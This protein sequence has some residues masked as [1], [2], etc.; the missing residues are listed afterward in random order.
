MAKSQA[1][2]LKESQLKGTWFNVTSYNE[3]AIHL[4]QELDNAEGARS[5]VDA[6]IRYAWK[7]YQQEPTR[8]APPWP[9]AADLTSPYAR[10]Y[11]DA[12]QARLMQTIF[13]DPVW[14]VEGWGD[15]AAKAPFVEEFHQR[16]LEEERL[17]SYL[18]EVTQRALVERV[19]ILEISEAMEWQ[20]V[21]KTINAQWETDEAGAPLMDDKNQPQIV[22]DDKG[23]PVEAQ[24]GMP[25]ATVQAD[26]WEPV[27]VGPAYDVVPYLDFLQLPGHARNKSHV[28]GFAKRFHRRVPQLQAWVER[29]LYDKAAVEAVG[30]ENEKATTANDVPN[31]RSVADQRGPTAQKELWEVQL[32]ANL[33]GKGERWYRATLHREKRQLLRLKLDDRTTRFLRFVPFPKAGSLDGY[34]L[35]TDVMRTVIEEDTAVRNMRADK[36]ALAIAAPIQKRQG[37]LWDEYEQPLGP[38]SVITVRDDKEVTQM[39]LSDVPTSINIWKQDIR[40]DSDRLVGQ[41][42]T[43]LGVDSGEDNTLGEERLR[44]SY[45][46]I[47]VDL[48]VKRMK[49]PMEELWQ[50]RHAIWQ[51]TLQSQQAGTLPIIQK[52]LT[53]M[54][55]NGIEVG[56]ITDGQITADAL[57]GAFWGKPRGSVETADLSRQRMDFVALLN[58]LPGLMQFNPMLAAILQ[59]P[60]ASKSVIE[61]LLR[62]FRWPDKQAFLGSAAQQVMQQMQQQQALMQDPQM[63]M[64]LALAGGGGA[65]PAAH[66]AGGVPPGAPSG[67]PSPQMP[68]VM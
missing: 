10:E 58:V 33:D 24:E 20:R 1:Y 64:I 59:T 63:Q 2:D 35:V 28:W 68:G 8:F 5:G 37:A 47:R 57:S 41:N 17:Q 44:A 32:L 9:G 29:G 6:E 7:L 56:N 12:L 53:G 31:E 11:V 50:A 21:S 39:Q 26:V 43:S 61:Q 55:A 60:D 51:R 18:D 62:V 27:R 48:L 54:S 38:R 67:P 13:V 45:V 42:D 3:L 22:R 25:S 19:G 15:A 52:A 36:A 49:E 40:S 34:S 66:G 65:G 30:T 16:T 46:E 4:A 23:N 14:T